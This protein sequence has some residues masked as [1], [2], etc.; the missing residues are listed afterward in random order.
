[1]APGSWSVT[2]WKEGSTAQ[3][4]EQVTLGRS[5]FG[6]EVRPCR[7]GQVSSP[8]DHRAGD[9]PH[10]RVELQGSSGWRWSL[11]PASR[12][13]TLAMDEG[14]ETRKRESRIG[15][16]SKCWDH[17]R[18]EA[19]GEKGAEEGSSRWGKP[20]ASR[21]GAGPRGAWGPARLGSGPPGLQ[22]LPARWLRPAGQRQP[23]SCSDHSIGDRHNQ[24]GVSSP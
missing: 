24:P 12:Q 3:R 21:R 8:V 18:L 20:G 5:W 23:F 9:V 1:M 15:A 4:T 19:P 7:Q 2:R 6:G 17:G 16:R 13:A 10:A 22:V 14:P 11:G